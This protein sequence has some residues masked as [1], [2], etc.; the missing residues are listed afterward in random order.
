[1]TGMTDP[2]GLLFQSPDHLPPI[3]RHCE[4]HGP[5]FIQTVD[6]IL[7]VQLILK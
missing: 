7:N 5:V 1:M 2:N 6:S 4:W 3:S